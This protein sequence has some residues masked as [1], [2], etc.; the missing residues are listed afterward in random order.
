M[1]ENPAQRSTEAAAR[2]CF[3]HCP[4]TS[5]RGETTEQ[6]VLCSTSSL[7]P[8]LSLFSER[9]SLERGPNR[10]SQ[11]LRPVQH[12][13]PHM[14]RSYFHPFRWAAAESI[15]VPAAVSLTSIDGSNFPGADGGAF[16]QKSCNSYLEFSLSLA[17]LSRWFSAQP[18]AT[19]QTVDGSRK[20]IFLFL[21]D[22]CS[23]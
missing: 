2:R 21:C 17:S 9:S 23:G 4:L 5:A 22:F 20:K 15:P 10:V 14:Q 6:D 1:L 19:T 12:I 18:P 16:P 11:A 3:S 8:A 7:R 13:R